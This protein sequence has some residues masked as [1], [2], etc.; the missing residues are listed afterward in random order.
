MARTLAEQLDRAGVVAD[1]VEGVGPA[2]ALE[3]LARRMAGAGGPVVIVPAELVL[4]DAALADLIDDPRPGT[5]LLVSRLAGRHDVQLRAGQVVAASSAQHRVG[6]PD[7]RSTGALL[8][9]AADLESAAQ[10]ALEMAGVARRSG[11]VADPVDLL[12]VALVRRR[13]AVG[14]VGIDPWPWLRD[15]SPEDLRRVEDDLDRLD[16]HRVRLTRATRVDDGFVASLLI[17]PLSRRLTPVALRLGLRP[18]QV[19]VLSLLVGLGA[20]ACFASGVGTALV[21][22][23]VLLQLSL[24]IDCVD[25]EVARYT[26]SFSSFGAWLDASTDRVKEFACYAG[27]ALGYET[28][29]LW[30]LAAAMLTLQTTRHSTDYTFTAVKELRESTLP[31]IPLDQRDDATAGAADRAGQRAASLVRASERSN[32][33]PAVKWTKRVAHMGIG[34]RWLVISVLAALN[35]PRLVFV[36]LLVL[37]VLSLGYTSAGR[38]L[39]ARSWPAAAPGSRER[40]LVRTQLD[41]GPLLRRFVRGRGAGRRSSWRYLWVLPPGLRLAE[42]VVVLGVAAAYDVVVAS[43]ALLVV[44]AYHHYDELYRVLNRLTPTPA[45]IRALGLG[46]DGR[47]LAVLALALVGGSVLESGL[48]LLA[49]GLGM[50][51]V[52]LGTFLAVHDVRGRGP[53][54][55][56]VLGA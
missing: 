26:R 3:Q 9:G 51:F 55:R 15:G 25:G 45:A 54:V 21:L 48:W 16:A 47:L 46:V 33:R 6:A 42:Y 18:N 44:V 24:V 37:G 56:E 5:R 50:V 10:A 28:D 40:E 27:L 34:E 14:A 17:R 1:V 31:A 2:G 30:L 12:L 53:Q 35:E 43:F 8:V 4:H 49:A 41:E 29:A 38:V 22:G 36:T 7:A 32:E 23:A 19:T 20:A 52:V 13:V 39:R 11:W